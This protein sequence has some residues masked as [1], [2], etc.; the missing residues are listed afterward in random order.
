MQLHGTCCWLLLCSTHRRRRRCWPN[1]GQQHTRRLRAVASLDEV[2]HFFPVVLSLR[3][4]RLFLGLPYASN[5]VSPASLST[6]LRRY[7]P[8]IFVLLVINTYRIYSCSSSMKTPQSLKNLV[9][10]FLWQSKRFGGTGT[11]HDLA[12]YSRGRENGQEAFQEVS[13]KEPDRRSFS[14]TATPSVSW[15]SEPKLCVSKDR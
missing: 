11:L 9:Y 1:N 8:I 6:A 13:I 14:V 10:T 2:L 5:L 12:Q 15:G 3:S 4:L 7:Q